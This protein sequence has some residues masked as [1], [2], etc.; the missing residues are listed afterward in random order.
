MGVFSKIISL[1]F[2][3]FLGRSD[4]VMGGWEIR[5]SGRQVSEE[6][7]PKGGSDDE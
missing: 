6:R 4:L 5:V 1:E 2:G 3:H 7:I